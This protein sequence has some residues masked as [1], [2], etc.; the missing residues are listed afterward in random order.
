M[1][2]NVIMVAALAA[3][4]CI[5]ADTSFARGAGG[6]GHIGGGFGHGGAHAFVGAPVVGSFGGARFGA[7]GRARI[8]PGVGA[9]HGRAGE[10]WG[11]S[12]GR[13]NRA[14]HFRHRYGWAPLEGYDYGCPD[15]YRTGHGPYRCPCPTDPEAPCS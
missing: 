13:L 2:R 9:Y 12:R 5:G 3:T 1:L 6:G 15:G 4:V 7:V 10:R 14:H 11:A 8:E